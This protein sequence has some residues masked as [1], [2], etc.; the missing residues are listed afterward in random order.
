M[1]LAQ[2]QGMSEEEFGKLH[3]YICGWVE[4]SRMP[5]RYGRRLIEANAVA[6]TE[7]YQNAL[8]R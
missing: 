3:K 6:I 8:Y 7:A 5:E 4:E 1:A 2:A